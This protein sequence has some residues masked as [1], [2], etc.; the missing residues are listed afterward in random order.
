M[1]ADALARS[2]LRD[3]AVRLRDESLPR[4]ERCLD[5]LD[6][7]AVWSRPNP[8][9]NSPGNLV[10]HLAGNLR[11]WIVG[12][13]GGHPSGRNRAAEFAE[14]GPVPRADLLRT[15]RGAV[16]EACAVLERLG[17][18]DLLAER[19]IQGFRVDGVS[20]VIHVVEHMSYHTGQIAYRTKELTARP[21][22]FYDEANR[23]LDVP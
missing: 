15:L 12:G 9:S 10:L 7:E 5:R 1:S 18:D 14:R 17:P 3:A 2:L 8:E 21:T 22:D 13:L 19:T 11:Q 6:D 4:I 23:D 16:E 20:V